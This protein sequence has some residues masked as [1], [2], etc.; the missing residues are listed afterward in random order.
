M[1]GAMSFDSEFKSILWVLLLHQADVEEI[2]L[3][4]SKLAFD[5]TQL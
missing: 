3:T 5:M 1:F 2:A 4:L